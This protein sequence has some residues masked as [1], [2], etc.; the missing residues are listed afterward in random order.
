MTDEKELDLISLTAD[1]VSAY[2]THNVLGFEKL[3]DF[4]GS[5]HAALSN[6]G[7]AGVEPP[8][9]EL[10]P[11][12]SIKKS[13]TSEYLICL[14]DGKKFKSLK[15][16]LSSVYNMSPE[17]YREKWGLP[18]DY[19]MVAP[20]YAEARSKLAK[21]MGLGRPEGAKPAAE[22]AVKES[23][24]AKEPEPEA[25]AAKGGGKRGRKAA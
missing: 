18:R 2:V 19:P 14:E 11:A 3:P 6:V 4:I 15:R 7:A 21:S 5:V 23:E 1:I 12:V 22:L 20:A 17:Q 8:M 25:K 16:H 13:L 10:K 9:E 24:A